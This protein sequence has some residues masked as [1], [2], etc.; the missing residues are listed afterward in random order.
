M[1]HNITTEPWE[2]CLGSLHV[3]RVL[4]IPTE[5]LTLLFPL[6]SAQVSL[7]VFVCTGTYNLYNL[8]NLGFIAARCQYSTSLYNNWAAGRSSGQ[9][10]CVYSCMY[11]QKHAET[12][13]YAP[14]AW[15]HCPPPAFPSDIKVNI[16][17]H[18]PASVCC[19]FRGREAA[20][21]CLADR[22]ETQG[23]WN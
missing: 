18:R 15:H 7:N 17:L 4:I 2:H 9:H 23:P 8:Y 10:C 22:T 14:E 6:S 1:E 21:V 5:S 11:T 20:A 12:V 13:Q 16:H 3:S 19:V